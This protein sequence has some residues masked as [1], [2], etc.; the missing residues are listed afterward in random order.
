MILGIDASNIKAGGGL[1]HLREMLTHADPIA[2]GITKV[3]VWGGNQLDVFEPKDWLVLEKQSLL[4]NQTFFSEVRW[5]IFAFPKLAEKCD[6]VFSPGGIILTRNIPYVPMSQNMLV[7]ESIERN[8]FPFIN[9]LRYLILEVLQSRTFIHASSN[10]FIS[11]YARDFINDKYP[12]LK[13][14][15]SSVIYHGISERFR[16]KPKEQKKI[17][18]YSTEKPF[19]LLYISRINFHKHQWNLIKAVKLLFEEG[20]PIELNLVG[21]ADR[22][23]YEKMNQELDGSETYINYHGPIPFEKISEIYKDNDLFVFASSCENM[24][25][26]LVEAMSA[27]LPIACSNYGPMPEILRDAGLYFDPLM[28]QSIK[29]ILNEMIINEKIRKECANKA[30]KYSK[31]FSWQ[32]CADKT[33]SF[34]SERI[35]NS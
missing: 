1:T 33:F 30:F 5:K 35:K 9:K 16:Q 31:E 8:R 19:K 18:N 13:S 23:A 15:P 11:N 22:S 4:I 10:I 17:S 2:Y 7:F 14:I 32:K 34:L 29:E 20:L 28:P 21:S 3:I 12:K 25:N 6:V 26:I 24:P 27:G